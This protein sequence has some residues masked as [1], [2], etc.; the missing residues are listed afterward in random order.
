MLTKALHRT[1]P[2]EFV[3]RLDNIIVFHTL[4]ED[5]LA[6]ILS[7]EIRPLQ[8]RMEAMGYDLRLTKKTQQA[9]LQ[10]AREKQFGARPLK[11]AI[12]TLVE[13][14]LTDML[15]VG[16]IENKIIKI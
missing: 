5:A 3:N 13:D 8:M 10:M 2:P 15:L 7:L 1:F 12:Q 4:D 16:T 11:R 9:I 6:Q 14:P